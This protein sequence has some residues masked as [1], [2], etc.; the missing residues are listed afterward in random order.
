VHDR[1]I[2]TGALV[3]HTLLEH[4]FITVEPISVP[5][6]AHAPGAGEHWPVHMVAVP[7]S[8]PFRAV[9]TSLGHAV[10]PSSH[11]SGASQVPVEGRH[12][13]FA[14][15]GEHIPALPCRAHD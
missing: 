14:P 1:L 12:T 3:T 11:D 6:V 8:A 13:T 9:S 10:A 4:A 2:A 7:Q 15:T 5:V